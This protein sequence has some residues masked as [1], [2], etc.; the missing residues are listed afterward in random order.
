MFLSENSYW[1]LLH[2]ARKVDVARVENI[3]QTEKNTMRTSVISS[4]ITNWPLW[5]SF[6]AVWTFPMIHPFMADIFL[7]LVF[8]RLLIILILSLSFLVFRR[9]ETTRNGKR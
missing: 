2:L 8:V 5:R 6:H 3:I 1:H 4:Y 9:R 7:D